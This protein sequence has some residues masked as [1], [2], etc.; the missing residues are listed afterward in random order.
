MAFAYLER[1]LGRWRLIG[2]DMSFCTW[3]V[4]MNGR[5]GMEMEKTSQ[6]YSTL[7]IGIIC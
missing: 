6:T 5:D 1:F 4:C 3:G 7:S 2:Y